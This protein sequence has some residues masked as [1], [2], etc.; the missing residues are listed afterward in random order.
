M[1]ANAAAAKYVLTVEP[2]LPSKCVGCGKSSD[3]KLQFVDPGASEDY[4]GAIVFCIDCAREICTLIG[5]VSVELSS[6]VAE[7]NDG[8]K[9]Q[10]ETYKQKVEALEDVV[11][12]YGLGQFVLPDEPGDVLATDEVK[13][14]DDF[15]PG[16]TDSE[17]GESESGLF[18]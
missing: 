10:L 14:S 1:V 8:L 15:I 18:E 2:P 12:V 4:Y 11:R 17:T 7:E 16:T 13:G 3:G 5:Y 9:K 6:R